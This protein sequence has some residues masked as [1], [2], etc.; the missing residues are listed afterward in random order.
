M[1]ARLQSVTKL[2]SMPLGGKYIHLNKCPPLFR[3]GMIKR[4]IP[5]YRSKGSKLNCKAYSMKSPPVPVDC[6]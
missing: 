1:A 2:H 3:L 6:D 5:E 4:N